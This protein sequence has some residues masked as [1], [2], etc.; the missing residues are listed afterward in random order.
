M[1]EYKKRNPRVISE[2][3][4]VSVSITKFH[5]ILRTI[6]H[7]MNRFM[8]RSEAAS[9]THVPVRVHVKYAATVF[10]SHFKRRLVVTTADGRT[11]LLCSYFVSLR[12]SMHAG[13]GLLPGGA[14]WQ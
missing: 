8:Q 13:P 10:V 9:L 11:L 14:L 3:H 5:T 6:A 12:Y 7:F 4:I 2:I 1:P